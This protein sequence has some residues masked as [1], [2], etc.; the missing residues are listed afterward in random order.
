M[1]EIS[2]KSIIIAEI[3]IWIVAA[4]WFAV[5]YLWGAMGALES[6]KDW[7]ADKCDDVKRHFKREA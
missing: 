4:L 7:I 6:I 3:Y 2:K 5:G 1:K